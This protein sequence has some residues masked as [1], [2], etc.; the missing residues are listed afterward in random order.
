MD[1]GPNS[2]KVT[3]VNYQHDKA[4]ISHYTQDKS[5]NI[6]PKKCISR[7]QRQI[8]AFTEENFPQS[9]SKIKWAVNSISLFYFLQLE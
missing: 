6:V 4:L 9:I 1:P 5:C 8:L 7:D 3:L 2:L